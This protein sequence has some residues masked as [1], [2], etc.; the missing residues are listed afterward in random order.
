M[1]FRPG[2]SG[3]P[4]GRAPTLK[5]GQPTPPSLAPKIS[6]LSIQE[7]KDL[8]DR[9]GLTPAQFLM[10][11]MV[12]EKWDMGDRIESAKSLLPYFHRKMPVQVDMNNPMAG[13]DMNELM[14]LPKARREMLLAT[15]KELGVLQ[16]DTKQTPM[17][18]RLP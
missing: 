9:A 12:D 6:M 14:K 10:S 17:V 2:K 13:L 1:P 7:R 16:D 18:E 8:V 5:P 11:V 15:F 4:K 3:N